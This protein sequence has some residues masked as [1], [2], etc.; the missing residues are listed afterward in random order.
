MQKVKYI[1]L[2][3]L[4]VLLPSSFHPY[5][6]NMG[7]NDIERGTV[8]TP[9]IIGLFVV[10]LLLS[11]I[12]KQMS[13]KQM[14]FRM[15]IIFTL[16]IFF[17]GLLIEGLFGENSLLIGDLRAILI[18]LGACYIGYQQIITKNNYV[19]F[20]IVFCVSSC[21][22]GLMQI[23]INGNGFAIT[24]YFAWQK[25][26][27]GG[28]IATSIVL[29][30]AL[31]TSPEFNWK[32]RFFYLALFVIGVAVILTIRARTAA[33][34]ALVAILLHFY[35]VHRNKHF[36]RSVIWAF[37]FIF[38]LSIVLPDTVSTYVTDSF[39]S[40]YGDGDITSG[41]T[42]R[43]LAVLDF[44]KDNLLTGS[45]GSNKEL[46]VAHNYPLYKLYQY[47]IL[48][49]LPIFILYVYI[50]WYSLK[51]I[52]T[53]KKHDGFIAIGTVTLFIPYMIS[54]GEY[55]FPFGPGTATVINFILL[56]VSLQNTTVNNLKRKYKV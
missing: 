54:M 47:G 14:F 52:I 31:L 41:R 25:N 21:Y 12:E 9:F 29:S 23:F 18:S 24:D 32:W 38:V 55:T 15:S 46:L 19:L 51:R 28:L 44:L 43:N 27:L 49:S 17:V 30:F 7:G 10:L 35:Y 34:A 37:I 3:I 45:L 16:V 1:I 6:V 13:S 39:T 2:L 4:A 40:G 11:L 20:I 53:V 8:L 36:G 26:A 22:A 56:G 42:V 50:L 5:I 33:I 48:F